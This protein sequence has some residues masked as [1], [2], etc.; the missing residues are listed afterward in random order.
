MHPRR[1]LAGAGA[2]ALVLALGA[3]RQGEPDAP[4]V[5]A[6]PAPAM[7]A[8]AGTAAASPATSAPTAAAAAATSTTDSHWQCGDQRVAARFD[9]ASRSLTL[10]HERGQLALPAVE[11]ASGARYAD[12]N[13]NEFWDKA[14]TAM[15]T[16]SGTP[17]RECGKV[18]GGG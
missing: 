17:A 10:I 5:A 1:F 7:P 4:A 8:A 2:L 6:G 13:G 14:D 15:L 18:A 12:A 3:C 9:P 16:L 11:S